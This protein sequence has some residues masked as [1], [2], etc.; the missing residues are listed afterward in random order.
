MTPS[1]HALAV[2]TGGVPDAFLGKAIEIAIVTRNVTTTMQGLSRIGIGPWRTYT[3]TPENTANQTY[4]GEPSPFVMRVCFAQLGDLI[5]ELI[6]P[7][8][9]RTIFQEFLDRHG[10][11]IHHIAF[12]CNG[13][14]FPA[15][16][17]EFERRGFKL[18]QGG[19]WMGT[20][21]FAFF[22]TEGDTTTCIET[23]AFPDDWTYPEQDLSYR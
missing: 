4:R 12:D 23:Y 7:L 19:S 13:I 11:G 8:S 3:F 9:G 1:E 5:W 6:Q 17:A 15:R 18:S 20:N 16:L 22:D 10:E 2:H 21:H 14:P